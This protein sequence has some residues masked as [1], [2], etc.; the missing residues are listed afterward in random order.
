MAA[1]RSSLGYIK[2]DGKSVENG[3]L[4]ARKTAY[5]LTG[6][7][8]LLK[9]ILVRKVPELENLE[10]ELPVYIE[11][12]S[13]VINIPDNFASLVYG[14]A[15]LSLGGLA[16]IWAKEYLKEAGKLMAQHDWKDA[17]LGTVMQGVLGLAQDA[18]RLTKHV[19]KLGIKEFPSVEINI[20]SKMIGVKNEKGEVQ[21]FHKSAL[22]EFHRFGPNSFKRLGRLV[23]VE[24]ELV[25]GI[26]DGNNNV[27]ER[28]S[29]RE[30]YLFVPPDESLESPL[31]PEMVHDAPVSLEGYA[32]RGTLTTNSIGF[33]YNSHIL[34]CR[35][36]EGSIVRF[37]N[38][39]FTKCQIRGSVDRHYESAAYLSKKPQI[40]FDTLNPIEPEIPGLFA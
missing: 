36:R 10:F 18:V 32:T 31:F 23:Q 35:P 38:A 5:A 17:G 14:G 4:D 27:E 34:T 37:R 16:V 29:E 39:L 28:I 6:A 26:V 3:V 25:I 21:F 22:E 8:L 7:E 11:E 19:G 12:G 24:R 1:R 20:K 13:L 2:L 33:K 40:I 15:V 9:A 30:K